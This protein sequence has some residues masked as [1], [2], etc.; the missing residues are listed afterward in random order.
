MQYKIVIFMALLVLT[1]EGYAQ[2]IKRSYIG[3]GVGV[4]ATPKG[5]D[6]GVGI[7]IKGGL[8]LDQILDNLGAEMELNFSV[9]NPEVNASKIAIITFGTYL[10]YDI[11]FKNSPISVRPKFGFVLPNL[12]DSNSVNSRNFA[13]S[14]G[15]AA[16][17]K[18]DDDLNVYIDYTNLGESVNNYSAGV[19]FRF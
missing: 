4:L 12:G 16:V 7:A 3:S 6:A 17:L 18:I 11:K 2:K 8:Y 15:I 5:T 19:E 13:L 1:V 14:S 9:K 10:T